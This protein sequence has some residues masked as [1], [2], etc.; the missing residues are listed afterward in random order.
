MEWWKERLSRSSLTRPIPGPVSVLALDAF[1]DASSS[2]GVGICLKRHWRAW[3][4]AENWT[5]NGREQ[6]DIGW[7]EA[8]GFELLI[9]AIA[10]SKPLHNHIRVYGDN[11]GV[12]EGWRNGRSRNLAV[13]TVFRRIHQF[14]QAEGL[15]IYPS[16]VQSAHNPAD[17]PS[18]GIFPPA[19]LLIPI[20]KIP[21]AL[22]GVIFDTHSKSISTKHA[23]SKPSEPSGTPFVERGERNTAQQQEEEDFKAL[24]QHL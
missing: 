6:R 1:S 10:A 16:Y 15:H 19:S 23:Q 14:T 17:G 21:E 4:L 3:A 12:V 9:H 7:A 13:N 20:F 2:V 24:R 8:V 5:G 18:R 22:E 11:Q